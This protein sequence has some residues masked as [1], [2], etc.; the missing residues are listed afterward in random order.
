MINPFYFTDRKLK[1]GFKINL[2]STLI[3]HT[4]SKLT[5]IPIYPEFEIEVR[6]FNKIIIV[7]SV[8]YARLLNL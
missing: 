2:D 1:V 3:N 5:I 8:I 6:C 4:N 7:L